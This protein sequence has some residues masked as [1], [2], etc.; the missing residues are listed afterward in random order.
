MNILNRIFPKIASIT[1]DEIRAEIARTEAEIA[2][3]RGNLTHAMGD[4]A[5][6]TDAEHLKAEANIAAINRAITRLEARANALAAELPGVIAAET[7]AAKAEAD[8]ALRNRAEAARKATDKEAAKLLGEYAKH[9]AHIGDILTRLNEIGRESEAV[10]QALRDN[11]VAE[12]VQ[13]YDTIHRKAPDRE[14]S[15]QRE[16]R[17]VWVYPQDGE[18]V[19]AKRR[20]N[21]EL[22]PPTRWRSSAHRHD[23]QPVLEKREIVVASTNFRRGEYL[24]GLSAVRLP[25]AFAGN[26]HFY[27]RS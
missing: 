18:V 12:H 20:D 10:N 4:V 25:G 23:P 26:A 16:V 7:A 17:E 5:T 1:S 27:P 15:E 8:Q 6:M 3:H 21:G 11:P 9:A 2:T 22:V 19:E 13:N 24:E 14:A